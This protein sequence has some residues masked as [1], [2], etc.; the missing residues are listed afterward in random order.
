MAEMHGVEERLATCNTDLQQYAANDPDRYRALRAL[1]RW[2]L[3]V[4]GGP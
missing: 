4:G 3:R 1:P 2:L